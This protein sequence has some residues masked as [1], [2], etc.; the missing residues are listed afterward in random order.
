L[1]EFSKFHRERIEGRLVVPGK[2]QPEDLT[3]L[4]LGR[5]AV[6]RSPALQP[7][8]QFILEIADVEITH[9]AV[10]MRAMRSLL[11]F[12]RLSVKRELG[13]WDD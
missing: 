5:A 2:G 13:R 9:V 1:G 6:A 3:M 7:E 12:R 11:S 8:N 4:R 10:A